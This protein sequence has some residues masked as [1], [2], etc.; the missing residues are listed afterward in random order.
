MDERNLIT[1]IIEAD[2]YINKFC[3]KYDA[4]AIVDI[5][6]SGH[7]RYEYQGLMKVY[8]SR[9]GLRGIMDKIKNM[10]SKNKRVI[11]ICGE[12][13]E[14]IRSAS[15]SLADNIKNYSFFFNHTIV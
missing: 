6:D 5:N 9:T 1:D 10:V 14:T 11:Q 13:A 12:P 4:I 8:Y 3:N 7:Y 2:K 15:N